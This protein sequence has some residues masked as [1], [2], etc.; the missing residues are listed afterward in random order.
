MSRNAIKGFYNLLNE[1][2]QKTE[3]GVVSGHLTSNKSGFL[4]PALTA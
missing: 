3:D 4:P 1:I 2:M